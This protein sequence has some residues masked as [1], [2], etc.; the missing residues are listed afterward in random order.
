MGSFTP[1]AGLAVFVGI[2]NNIN[3]ISNFLR[4]AEEN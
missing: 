3:V 4:T 2:K 1:K